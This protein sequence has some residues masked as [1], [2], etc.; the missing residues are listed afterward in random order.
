M[1][2]KQLIMSV[3]IIGLHDVSEGTKVTVKK[4]GMKNIRQEF[5]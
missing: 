3:N 2:F 1:L 5:Y 4:Q